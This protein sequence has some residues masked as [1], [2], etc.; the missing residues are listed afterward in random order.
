[1]TEVKEKTIPR[2][3][4]KYENVVIPALMKDFNY[5]NK[6]QVPKIEKIVVNI[7]IGEYVQN[8][9]I[10]ENVL[11]DISL[12]TGQ[13]PIVTKAKKSIAGFKLRAGMPNGVKVTLRASRMYEFLDKLIT[14]NLPRIRD[15]RGISPRGFDGKG[16]FSLGL[17]EQLIFPEIDY[18]KIDKIRGLQ[19]SIVTTAKTDKEAKALLTYI[20]FPFKK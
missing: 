4:D 18:D 3:K 1:M 16:N 9:K 8:T 19:I 12:I 11:R 2:L 7:G 13:K 20:G 15:F 10:L 6:M 17:K 14:L 5:K